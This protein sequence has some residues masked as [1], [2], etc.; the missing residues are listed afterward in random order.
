M[1]L[2]EKSIRGFRVNVYCT[3]RADTI[4]KLLKQLH[5]ILFA[6]QH[7]DHQGD[8]FHCRASQRDCPSWVMTKL[9]LDARTEKTKYVIFP[10]ILRFYMIYVVATSVITEFPAYTV[11][12]ASARIIVV[13]SGVAGSINASIFVVLKLIITR[14]VVR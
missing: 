10:S 6:S 3:I 14:T 9:T 4:Q 13:S 5:Y 11:L 8:I 7:L 2:L 12:Y 1:R